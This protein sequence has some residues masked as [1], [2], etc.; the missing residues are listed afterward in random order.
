MHTQMVSFEELGLVTFTRNCLSILQTWVI[1]EAAMMEVVST[2]KAQVA[3]VEEAV[4]CIG[5]VVG[6]YQHHRMLLEINARSFN[7]T[8]KSIAEPPIS[9]FHTFSYGVR[10]DILI[11][12]YYLFH[13]YYP[14]TYSTM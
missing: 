7:V 9:V 2:V 8:L 6:S 4:P 11:H 12:L 5:V 13:T 10:Q 1:V 14:P 3:L